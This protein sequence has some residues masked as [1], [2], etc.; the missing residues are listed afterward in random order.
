M[1]KLD[2]SDGNAGPFD[3][4]KIR[5]DLSGFAPDSV[6]SGGS[7]ACRVPM[8]MPMHDDAQTRCSNEMLGRDGPTRYSNEI[9]ELQMVHRPDPA[10]PGTNTR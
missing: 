9:L 5:P 2:A 3:L 6:P 8:L 7:R 10:S 4:L 1:N